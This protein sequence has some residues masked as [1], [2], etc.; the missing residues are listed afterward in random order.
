MGEVYFKMSVFVFFKSFLDRPHFRV[1]NEKIF[2]QNDLP[3]LSIRIVEC[4]QFRDVFAVGFGDLGKLL[5]NDD[6]ENT[7]VTCAKSELD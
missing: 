3:V 5:G 2:V 7:H 4:H 1:V 6:G